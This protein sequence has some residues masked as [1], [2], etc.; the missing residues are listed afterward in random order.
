V[1]ADSLDMYA[2]PLLFSYREQLDRVVEEMSQDI[3]RALEGLEPVIRMAEEGINA[4]ASVNTGASGPGGRKGSATPAPA[5]TPQV[6]Y[7][8]LNVTTFFVCTPGIFTT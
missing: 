3:G 4:L 7:L 8:E 6:P 1:C 5:P 2:S